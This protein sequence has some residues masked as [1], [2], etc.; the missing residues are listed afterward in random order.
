MLPLWARVDLGAIAMKGYSAF[1]KTPTLPSDYLVS[2]P[3]YSFGV[4]SYPLQR[5]SRCILQPQLTG[6]RRTGKIAHEK[7]KKS[8]TREKL[9]LY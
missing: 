6:Q 4:G 7:I 8:K 9:N 1:P 3:G 2:Y 5:S